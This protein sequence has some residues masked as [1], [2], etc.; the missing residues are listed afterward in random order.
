M[1]GKKMGMLVVIK[2]QN[3]NAVYK[4]GQ[5]VLT[6]GRGTAN[7]IQLLDPGVSRRHASLW[8]DGQGYQIRDLE[9]RNGIYINNMKIKE[10]RLNIGDK[11]KIGSVMFKL[12]DDMNNVDDAVLNSRNA[13]QNVVDRKT[14]MMDAVDPDMID[15]AVDNNVVDI[16][17][18]AHN[19]DVAL[20]RSTSR[21]SSMSMRKESKVDLMKETLKY[22]QR[23]VDADRCLAFRLDGPRKLKLVAAVFA[24]NVN[25]SHKKLQ[26]IKH[27]LTR[28]LSTLSPV[29]GRDEGDV[30]A[31]A[32]VPLN[33][34]MKT[35]GILYTDCMAENP[36]IFIDQDIDILKLVAPAVVSAI[37][38]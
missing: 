29:T 33:S 8:W 10:A 35:I 16:D 9:S 14:M 1:R 22:A 4:L 7:L 25:P 36:R 5:R 28:A 12:V 24:D 19:R 2:G 15:R 17:Q 13:D 34:G 23:T 26:P 20:Q 6:V 21:F 3:A 30:Y 27:V 31:A 32:A 38:K 11:I 18:T 37:Q